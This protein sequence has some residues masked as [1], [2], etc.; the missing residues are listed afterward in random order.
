MRGF[1]DVVDTEKNRYLLNPENI[2]FIHIHDDK[3]C[4]LVVDS[5]LKV[6]VELDYRHIVQA[7]T[8]ARKERRED[9]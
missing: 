2:S 6:K 3:S 4:L 9:E 1:V 7:V 5:K 8:K